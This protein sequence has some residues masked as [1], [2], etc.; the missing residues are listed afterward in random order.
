MKLLLLLLAAW[1]GAGLPSGTLSIMSY[2]IMDSGFADESGRYDPVGDR[3]T[4]NGKGN[5]TNF[6]RGQ[7]PFVDV[8][9]VVE[10]ED[11][12]VTHINL[13]ARRQQT[14]KLI[15]SFY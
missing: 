4:K 6:M 13:V 14:R 8:L 3:V 2:N 11:K 5:L 1:C 12:T 10:T 7:A 15:L 9:G